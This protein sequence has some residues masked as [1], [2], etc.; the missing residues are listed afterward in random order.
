MKIFAISEKRR[1]RHPAPK[2][3]L[4]VRTPPECGGSTRRTHRE[5]KC[6]CR[7]SDAN[8]HVLEF[9]SLSDRQKNEFLR[10]VT[11]LDGSTLPM[12][13]F[14][15]KSSISSKNSCISMFF[16]EGK[17]FFGDFIDSVIRSSN[18]LV[19][20]FLLLLCVCLVFL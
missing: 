11:L 12:V 10:S 6:K 15:S 13:D 19:Q 9:L 16:T 1:R 4:V 8:N 20:I 5:S 3:L 17:Y 14:K 7:H 18:A 2:S